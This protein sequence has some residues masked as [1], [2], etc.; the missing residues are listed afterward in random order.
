MASTT[1]SW[2]DPVVDGFVGEGP[3][4]RQFERA[5]ADMLSVPYVHAV[6]NGTIGLSLAL[7]AVGVGPGDKVIVPAFSMPATAN[8]VRFIGAIPVFADVNAHLTLSPSWV[9]MLAHDAR[10]VVHVSI[11]GR[12]KEIERV[13]GICSYYKIPLVEDACQSFG[14]THMGRYLGTVGDIGVYS[15]ST[16]KIITTGQG[17]AVVTN[18]EEYSEKIKLLRNFGRTGPDS[19]PFF[20]INA[21]FTDMQAELGL[22]QIADL[23]S[24]LKRKRS[25]YQQYVDRLGDKCFGMAGEVPLWVDIDTDDNVDFCERMG[26]MGIQC[27]PFYPAEGE[28]CNFALGFSKRGV[29]LPSSLSI[30]DQQIEDVC[31]AVKVLLS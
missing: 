5:I 6:C 4:T 2:C 16:P 28:G 24:R 27:R 26:K 30:T 7:W 23:F 31:R 22:K 17:G 14:S 21:K 13:A 3:A 9:N 1:V 8:A 15:F 10:A 12:G 19:Y 18:K 29:W 11:N 20:G 25:I